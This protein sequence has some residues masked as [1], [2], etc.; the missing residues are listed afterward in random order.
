MNATNLGLHSLMLCGCDA[1][2]LCRMLNFSPLKVHETTLVLSYVP[3]YM[4]GHVSDVLH[5]G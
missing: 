3:S 4:L 1:Q 5:I 2:R